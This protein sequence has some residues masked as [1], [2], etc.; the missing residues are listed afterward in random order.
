MLQRDI[1][2]T[3][4]IYW[5][6]FNF[7]FKSAIIADRPLWITEERFFNLL[8]FLQSRTGS[9]LSMTGSEH[10]SSLPCSSS[11][12]LHICRSMD[13]PLF[14]DVHISE[15]EAFGHESFQAAGTGQ[16]A[17]STPAICFS[18]PLCP[19]QLPSPH[20]P[21]QSW[22]YPT[23]C[24]LLRLQLL[25][26][27]AAMHSS[28]RLCC[29]SVGNHRGSNAFTTT[30]LN[31][32]QCQPMQTLCQPLS[33]AWLPQEWPGHARASASSPLKEKGQRWA[34]IFDICKKSILSMIFCRTWKTN[35]CY[36]SLLWIFI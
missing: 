4:K 6:L 5:Y 20:S 30:S 23:R 29:Q 11:W 7:F 3:V 13:F 31:T 16:S 24:T 25:G 22:L 12:F 2:T 32:F 15:K 26:P 36:V 17:A 35:L 27:M 21:A 28:S 19:C 18:C 10:F 34:L 1:G 33:L 9:Y 8:I 14:S